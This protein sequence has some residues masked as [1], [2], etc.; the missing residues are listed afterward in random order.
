LVDLR[1]IIMQFLQHCISPNSLLIIQ[2]FLRVLHLD[3]CS[4]QI[5]KL[6][7]LLKIRKLLEL[8]G[9]NEWSQLGTDKFVNTTKYSTDESKQIG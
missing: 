3:L 6:G 7:T 5:S 4:L 8:L 1:V 2:G 9:S